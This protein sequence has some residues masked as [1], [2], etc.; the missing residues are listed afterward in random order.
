MGKGTEKE[1]KQN[2]K[3]KKWNNN[4]TRK[5]ARGKNPSGNYAKYVLALHMNNNFLQTWF[6]KNVAV[7]TKENKKHSF[8]T[9]EHR[10][11]KH[12]QTALLKFSFALLLYQSNRSLIQPFSLTGEKLKNYSERERERVFVCL[13][14]GGRRSTS[15]L[16]S[17]LYSFPHRQKNVLLFFLFLCPLF[18]LFSD[19]NTKKKHRTRHGA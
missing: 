4:T 2:Q 6:V 7:N 13:S 14:S 5:E 12:E 8:E 3:I 15:S 10:T 1:H 16:P 17:F 9:M 18:V 19:K 11:K